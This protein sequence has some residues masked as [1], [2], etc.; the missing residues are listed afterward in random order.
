MSR[1]AL[2]IRLEVLTPMAY[3]IVVEIVRTKRYLR[4]L[5]RL[6][7]SQSDIDK[8]KSSIVAGP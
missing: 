2:V 4:D 5:A 1:A 3:V 7:A 6:G 8:L